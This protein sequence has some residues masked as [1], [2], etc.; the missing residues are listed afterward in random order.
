MRLVFS[1]RIGHTPFRLVESW[2]VT[3]PL[4]KWAA[5]AVILFV[6]FLLVLV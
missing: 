3:T 2:R 6:C 1:K 5:V 4:G